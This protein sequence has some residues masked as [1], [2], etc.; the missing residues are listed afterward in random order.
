MS[1]VNRSHARSIDG[2]R[3]TK[4]QPSVARIAPIDIGLRT[5][6]KGPV[7]MNSVGKSL[8]PGVPKPQVLKRMPHSAIRK[9]PIPNIK[10]PAIRN[11]PGSPNPN[12]GSNL[13]SSVAHHPTNRTAKRTFV[14]VQRALRA[15]CE[16]MSQYQADLYR[17]QRTLRISFLATAATWPHLID[18]GSKPVRDPDEIP[19]LQ[20]RRVLDPCGD[21]YACRAD[22]T[23]DLE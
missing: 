11:Q 16:I 2:E 15:C 9:R 21:G 10:K 5:W 18:T 22:S 4:L 17:G 1:R 20:I 23:C 12:L 7:A 19:H 14:I 3:L 13:R 6:R 8:C